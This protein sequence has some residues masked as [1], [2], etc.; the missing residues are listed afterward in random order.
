VEVPQF[1][2]RA[3][4]LLA[5]DEHDALIAHLAANPTAG[6]LVA[7]AGGIRKPRWALRGGG[8]HGGARVIHFFHSMELPLCALTIFA[9]NE[10]AD[11]SQQERNAFRLLTKTLVETYRKGKP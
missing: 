11:L 6:D 5:S 9:K 7:G 2:A 4:K 10:R 1:I 3:R 8:K